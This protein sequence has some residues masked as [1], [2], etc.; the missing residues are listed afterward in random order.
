MEY[1]IWLK[2]RL[3]TYDIG[4][5]RF[6]QKHCFHFESFAKFDNTYVVNDDII[7]RSGHAVSVTSSMVDIYNTGR[8]Q[9]QF[10]ID[11]KVTRKTVILH[12][13]LQHLST[14]Y[15]TTDF[16]CTTFENEIARDL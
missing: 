14:E 3:I 10:E 7:I 4:G 2:S 13:N 9:S 8:A 5:V 12:F 16:T 1:T 6:G 15:L 11:P